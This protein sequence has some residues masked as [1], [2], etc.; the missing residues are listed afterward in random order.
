M[1]SKRKGYRIERKIRMIFEK[2]G[3][4]VVRAGGSL[5]EADL[6]GIKKNKCVLLQVKSTSKKTF[7]FYDEFPTK[8]EG[9]SLFLVVDFGYG[10][11]RVLP[12][13]KKIL[14]T[15]GSSLQDFLTKQ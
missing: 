5:G 6:I 7:Y 10:N 13:Q 4:K 14:P 1:F 2:N 9:F 3:W 8:I 11:I 15:S 12:P